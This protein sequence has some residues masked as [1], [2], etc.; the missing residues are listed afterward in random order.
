V[1][2]YHAVGA[3]AGSVAPYWFVHDAASPAADLLRVVLDIFTMPL[4]YFV[5]GYFA[6]SSLLKRGVADFLRDKVV[7]LLIPWALGVL[8]VIPLVYYDLPDQSVRPF[9]SYWPWYL[10]SFETQLSTTSGPEQQSVHWF[11][12]L[13]FAFF[14]LLALADALIR[15]LGREAAFTAARVASD[16]SKLRALGIFGALTSALYFVSLLIFPDSS[17]LTLSAFLQF[18]PTRLAAYGG[19]FALGAYAQSRG[20]F[21]DLTPLGSLPLWS[22][23]SVALLGATL[24]A[25]WPLFDDAANPPSLP[26]LRLLAYAL[27]R[28]FLLVSLLVVLV[29]FG[30]R[31][32]NRSSRL[33][34][35]LSATSYDIYL[36]H[37]RAPGSTSSWA[38]CSTSGT[39]WTRRRVSS[40]RG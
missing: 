40:M 3:Y 39:A 5:A 33:D 10:G 19:C 37:R 9:A 4:V 2:L 1:V 17:W 38:D 18:Q 15:R 26:I 6:L 16:G 31:Y 11:I 8:V 20:W 25:G 27:S 22:G 24:V 7:R 14:L 36:T 13:L 21:A 23:V 30:V 29:S 28:S 32:W 34:R 12:S 35:Q